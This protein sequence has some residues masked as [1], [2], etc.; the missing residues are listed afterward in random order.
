M[1]WESRAQALQKRWELTDLSNRQRKYIT[2]IFSG[3]GL[4][5]L[6]KNPAR[7]VERERVLCECVFMYELNKK[8]NRFKYK[9]K[10]VEMKI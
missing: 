8:K 1:W 6:M 10:R 7:G 9:M 3:E 5:E 2:G 4:P